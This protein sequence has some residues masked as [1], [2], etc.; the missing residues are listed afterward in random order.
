MNLLK[1]FKRVIKPVFGLVVASAMIISCEN[2]NG[3]GGLSAENGALALSA[4]RTGVGVTYHIRTVQDLID[5]NN[6]PTGDYILDNPLTLTD[7]VP[8]CDPSQPR[9]A[10]FIG[11]F[12]GQGNTITLQ[13]FDTGSLNGNQYLGIFAKIGDGTTY[14]SVTVSNLTVDIET[15]LF[16]PTAAQY[17]G[18]LA[19]Y[20]DTAVF[21]NITVTGFLNVSETNTPVPLPDHRNLDVGGLAGYALSS[22][23]INI[24]VSEILNAT[25]DVPPSSVPKPEIWKG[26]DTFRA[27]YSV[28]ETG[29]NSVTASGVIGYA[30]DSQFRSVISSANVTAQSKTVTVYAGG[31]LGF[32]D[33]ATV[34]TSRASGTITGTAFG[35][36]TSA[37]GIAGYIVASRV[38]D[39]YATGN[40]SLTAQSTAFDYDDSWQVYAGGLVGYV[41][42]SNTA[43]SRIER[44][45]AIGNVSA[46]S[47][48]PYAG[49]LVGYL[50][51]F[52]DFSNPAKNGST[53]S[54]SYATGNV[55]ATA[56]DN[57]KVGDI[58]YA[59]G[60]VGYSSVVDSTIV[61]SYARGNA[62]ATTNG[63]YAWAGGIVGGNANDAVVLRTYATG[64]VTSNTGSLSPLY[65]PQYADAGPAGGGIAGFNYYTV[66]TSVG[67]SVALNSTV[68]GNQT[69]SQNVLHRV[70]GSLGNDAAHTGVLRNNLAYEKMNVT[71]NWQDDPGAD[72][73]DGDNTAAQ[74][75]QSVYTGLSWDFAGIW[76]MGSDGY[77]IL[78]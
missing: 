17:V 45:Y 13:S 60:L 69:A 41:G 43:P 22:S 24:N 12:D 35:Y 48:F 62:T 78:R 72:R 30:K 3:P 16:S 50:Y 4:S 25:F 47:P 36:N 10:A 57:G 53:V 61:D 40:V 27:R 20:T 21:T 58:P 19:G 66:N 7:W 8:I 18:G 11:T 59:G 29:Y 37:G 28:T 67:Y 34:G 6:D 52:N 63:T 54:R 5:V 39:S 56:L 65:E 75:A 55:I 49:G 64:D 23:F 9:G 2:V 1:L 77:P 14:P 76:T 73:R 70:A 32:G 46:T 26:D 74:P 51:G 42:G 15:G 33:G 71:D 38:T 68:H 44:S 31:V